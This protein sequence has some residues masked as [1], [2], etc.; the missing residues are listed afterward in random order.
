MDSGGLA[1]ICCSWQGGLKVVV[2]FVYKL[3]T[4]QLVA[5]QRA[6]VIV[7]NMKTV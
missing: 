2:Y 3:P 6:S 7:D 1:P 4:W 5:F